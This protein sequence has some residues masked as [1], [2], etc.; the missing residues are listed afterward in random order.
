M[1]IPPKIAE[2]VGS[3]KPPFLQPSPQPGLP[4][5]LRQSNARFAGLLK[6]G[7]CA[8]LILIIGPV[9]V[10]KLIEHSNPPEKSMAALAAASK[11][12]DRQGVEL[13]VDAPALSESMKQ[14]MEDALAWKDKHE[15]VLDEGIVDHFLG[16]LAKPIGNKIVSAIIDR[17]VT[18]DN[19]INLLCGEPVGPMM[20]S[21]LSGVANDATDSAMKL[22]GPEKQVYTPVIKLALGLC[23]DLLVDAAES[24]RANQTQP[25]DLGFSEKDIKTIHVFESS[26]RY[27]VMYKTPKPECPIIALEY[28]RHGLTV[29]K[30]SGVRFLPPDAAP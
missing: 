30:W 12:H 9:L 5:N 27:V 26:S 24:K 7:I 8:I 21:S 20:K 14:F 3:E 10:V 4:I 29:W 19:V 23:A 6:F 13:Y 25:Q 11:R 28:Q 22:A 15:I 17:L 1:A 2:V 16:Q 18:S